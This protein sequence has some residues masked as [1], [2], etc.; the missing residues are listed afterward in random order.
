MSRL[1]QLNQWKPLIQLHHLNPLHQL[2]H[3][4]FADLRGQENLNKAQIN[5]L[6]GTVC[7]TNATALLPQI[8][9]LIFQVWRNFGQKL[10]QYVQIQVPLCRIFRVQSKLTTRRLVNSQT[11]WKLGRQGD[12]I[13]F[14]ISR[15]EQTQFV[16]YITARFKS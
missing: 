14:F 11:G 12:R 2:N 16:L 7:Q 5:S 8:S 10:S 4:H 9:F 3:L 13:F 6:K 15:L 1:N